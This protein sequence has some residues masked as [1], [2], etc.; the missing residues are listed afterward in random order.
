MPLTE[1]GKNKLLDTFKSG[2]VDPS[3]ASQNY[4]AATRVYLLG[5]VPNTNYNN[6]VNRFGSTEDYIVPSWTVQGGALA[7]SFI[8]QENKFTIVPAPAAP[9]EPLDLTNV[10]GVEVRNQSGVTYFTGSFANTFN[11]FSSGTLTVNTVSLTLE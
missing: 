1:A 8:G 4:Q 6:Y 2:F 9:G 5:T 11:F 10:I 3:E 7:T